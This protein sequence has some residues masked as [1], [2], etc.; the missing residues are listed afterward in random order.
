MHCNSYIIY[1]TQAA[2]VKRF[3]FLIILATIVLFVLFFLQEDSPRYHNV[4][5]NAVGGKQFPHELL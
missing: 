1:Y 2:S 3:R 4:V 5:R